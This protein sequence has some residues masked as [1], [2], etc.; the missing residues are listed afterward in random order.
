LIS[1]QSYLFLAAGRE[2]K[3]VV[4]LLLEK[5]ANMN[6]QG[7]EYDN[8]LR[9]ASYGGLEQIVDVSLAPLFAQ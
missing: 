5:G 8:E 4:N 7:S 9:Q 6:A 1:I 3:G 2:Y